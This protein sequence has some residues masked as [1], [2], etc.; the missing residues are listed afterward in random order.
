MRMT[1]SGT[2]KPRDAGLDDAIVGDY[3]TCQI[4]REDGGGLERRVEPRGGFPRP[5]QHEKQIYG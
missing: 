2:P 1:R 4:R 5:P 3:R